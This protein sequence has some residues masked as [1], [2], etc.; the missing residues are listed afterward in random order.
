MR[1][2]IRAL[3]WAGCAGAWATGAVAWAQ[4][5]A[6]PATAPLCIVRN[7]DPGPRLA[8]DTQG[9]S[10]W[11]TVKQP[12]YAYVSARGA[13]TS[14]DIGH[15]ALRLLVDGTL[16]AGSGDV[17]GTGPLDVQLRGGAYLVPGRQYRFVLTPEMRNVTLLSLRLRIGA[18]DCS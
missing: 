7:L 18:E 4:T 15:I 1:G 9:L 13:G 8:G 2:W 16:L 12:T 10:A 17:A 3:G 5:A 11:V 14:L 6:T